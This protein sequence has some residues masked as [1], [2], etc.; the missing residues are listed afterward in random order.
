MWTKGRQVD[1]R[2][3]SDLEEISSCG[4]IERREVQGLRNEK[5]GGER[6]EKNHS[7]SSRYSKRHPPG[8]MRPLHGGI[9]GGWNADQMPVPGA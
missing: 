8:R 5:A 7:S 6:K 4:W 2:V 3:P 1:L 9:A